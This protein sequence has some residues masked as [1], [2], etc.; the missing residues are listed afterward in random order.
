[1][2]SEIIKHICT[3]SKSSK[4]WTKELNYVRWDIDGKITTTLDLRQWS[5]DHEKVGKGIGLSEE[6]MDKLA[7]EW[8]KYRGKSEVKKSSVKIPS[9]LLD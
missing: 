9:G 1:M 4:G 6:E 2:S 5:P 7:E 3:I 8:L